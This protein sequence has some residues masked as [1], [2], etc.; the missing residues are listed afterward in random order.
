[1]A[2]SDASSVIAKLITEVPDDVRIRTLQ[3]VIRSSRQNNF[4]T[5]SDLGDAGKKRQLRATY[6]APNCEPASCETNIC[7]GTAIE[8][9]V[10]NL[11]IAECTSSNVYKISAEHMRLVDGNSGWVE[12]ATT[13]LKQQMNELRTNL[14]AAI[15]AKLVTYVGNFADGSASKQIPFVDP[16]SGAIY[17]RGYFEIERAIQDIGLN[18]PYIVGGKDVFVWERGIAMGGLNAQ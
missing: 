11:A 10:L 5:I 7:D 18:D 9:A 13:V 17:P 8:P 1:M 14:N 2:W 15:A 3:A 16:A 4:I 12:Y 6:F